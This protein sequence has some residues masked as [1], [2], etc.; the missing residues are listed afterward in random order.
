MSISNYLEDKVLNHVFGGTSY[1]APSTLYIALF[2]TA[3]GED[4]SGGTEVT[5]TGTAYTRQ[6]GV[7]T[8]SSGTASNTSAIEYAIALANYGTVVAVGI[9]DASTSGNLLAYGNLN[10]TKVV[11]TGDIFRFNASDLSVTL[12]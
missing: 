2:T 7:F 10:S 8:V 1:T 5:T 12:A 6:T 9:Y 3:P 4:G 11:S